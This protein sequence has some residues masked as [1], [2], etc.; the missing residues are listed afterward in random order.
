LIEGV[1]SSHRVEKFGLFLQACW[2]VL[3]GRIYKFAVDEIL[4]FFIP[5]CH[6]GQGGASLVHRRRENGL[7]R[8]SEGGGR[9]SSL[10]IRYLPTYLDVSSLAVV[11][12]ARESLVFLG[13]FFLADI[14]LQ[15]GA[16]V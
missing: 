16:V 10:Q 13:V 2:G 5:E 11:Q 3:D 7:V 9:F 6:G 15:S 1:S 14:S 8:L 4:L 12:S